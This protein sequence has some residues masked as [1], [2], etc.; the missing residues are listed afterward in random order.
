[1]FSD[2]ML[3]KLTKHSFFSTDVQKPTSYLQANSEE[4]LF[5]VFKSGLK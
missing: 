1:M 4:L 3:L 5:N 2:G